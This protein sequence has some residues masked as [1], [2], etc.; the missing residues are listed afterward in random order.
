MTWNLLSSFQ[1]TDINEIT[2]F[3]PAFANNKVGSSWGIV[4]E[5]GTKVCS[6]FSTKKSTNIFRRSFAV[7]EGSI[8]IAVLDVLFE[9]LRK[10]MEFRDET[11]QFS[12]KHRPKT[13]KFPRKSCN[14][15]RNRWL[16]RHLI[17]SSPQFFTDY[18]FP[19]RLQTCLRWTLL[20]QQYTSFY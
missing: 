2:W 16:Q 18:L 8:L 9:T 11:N 13:M 10:R 15:G 7:N 4:D 17:L 6:Y 1:C 14:H 3:I 12:R 5:E 20:H 19:V